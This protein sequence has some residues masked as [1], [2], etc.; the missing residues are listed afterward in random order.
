MLPMIVNELTSSQIDQIN[1]VAQTGG[2]L[3]LKPTKK[4]LVFQWQLV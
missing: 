3:V 4:Q 1:R 2:K